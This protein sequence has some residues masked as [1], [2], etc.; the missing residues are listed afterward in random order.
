[1]RCRGHWSRW[2][3]TPACLFGRPVGRDVA[4]G[5]WSRWRDPICPTT[6]PRLAVS[7][8]AVPPPDA[9]RPPL[10][11]PRESSQG[12]RATNTRSSPVVM[13]RDPRRTSSGDAHQRLRPVHDLLV[14]RHAASADLVDHAGKARRR[15]STKARGVDQCASARSFSLAASRYAAWSGLGSMTYFATSS[16]NCGN[17]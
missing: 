6:T 5:H 4:G 10:K 14:V 3:L 11:A 2:R 12:P 17:R 8:P 15:A 13:G 7:T 1:M 16:T 9:Q